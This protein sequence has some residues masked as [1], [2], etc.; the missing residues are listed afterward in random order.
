MIDGFVFLR[1]KVIAWN[2]WS[3]HVQNDSE[4]MGDLFH[5]EITLTKSGG[6]KWAPYCCVSQRSSAGFKFYLSV[7]ASCSKPNTFYN[8]NNNNNAG[9][10]TFPPYFIHFV[11]RLI[12]TQNRVI[13]SASVLPLV[14]FRVF[15]KVTC[16]CIGFIVGFFYH[17]YVLLCLFLFISYHFRAHSEFRTIVFL[18]GCS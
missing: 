4:K 17:P 11:H 7:F 6:F 8:N 16:Y 2:A 12:V 15:G 14:I 18:H 10:T 5:T 9:V 13:F 3:Y 1:N